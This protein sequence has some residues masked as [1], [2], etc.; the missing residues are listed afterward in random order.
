MDASCK[1][2]FIIIFGIPI[3]LSLIVGWIFLGAETIKGG[4]FY[5]LFDDFS[6]MWIPTLLILLAGG[7]ID[8][9]IFNGSLLNCFEKK[10]EKKTN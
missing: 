8:R 6:I 5:G 4:E 7:I 9:F 1:K 2:T 3:I 10:T